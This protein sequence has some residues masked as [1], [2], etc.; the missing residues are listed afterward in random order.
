MSSSQS[1]SCQ[2]CPSATRETSSLASDGGTSSVAPH[3]SMLILPRSSIC[4][5]EQF[6]DASIWLVI[7]RL[8]AAIEIAP[9]RNPATGAEVPF[10]PDFASGMIR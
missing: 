7:T 3:H 4:V 6:A 9:A 1:G 2:T 5:G 10:T 8:L